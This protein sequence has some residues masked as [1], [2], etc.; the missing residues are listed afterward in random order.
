MARGATATRGGN[1]EGREI[2]RGEEREE[3]DVRNA[4]QAS[5]WPRLGGSGRTRTR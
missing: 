3:R 2:V 4:G 1:K 5:S